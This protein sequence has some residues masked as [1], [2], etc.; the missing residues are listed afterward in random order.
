MPEKIEE[1]SECVELLIMQKQLTVTQKVIS[2]LKTEDAF[3]NS[4]IRN[5]DKTDKFTGEN[6]H[7]K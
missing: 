6:N 2:T 5:H 3:D 4:K 7:L 1:A